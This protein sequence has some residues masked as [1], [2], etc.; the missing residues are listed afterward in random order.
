MPIQRTRSAA[1]NASEKAHSANG[2]AVPTS[3]GEKKDT[4]EVALLAGGKPDKPAYEREQNR[5]K[6][7]IDSL[8]AK[9]ATVRDKIGL[10][11]QQNVGNERRNELK[12]ELDSLRE[13]Q[14]SKKL[15]R[16]KL[17]DQVNSLQD[18]LQKKI[19]DLQAQKSKVSFKTVAEIDDRIASLEK[20]IES[21]NMKLADEKRALQE[22]S[23]IKRNR[24]IVDTFQSEQDAI[25]AIR[26]EIEDLKKQLDDPEAKAVSDRFETVKAELDEIKKENDEAYA[27]R[28]KLF[29]ERDNLNNQ[30]KDLLTEKRQKQFAYRDANDKYWAKLNED[31]A[32]RAE[33]QRAQRAAEEA[34]RK[35][36]IAQRI[37]DEAS[38]PAFQ[39]YIED[40]QTLVDFFSGKSSAT[41][42]PKSGSLLAKAEVAGVPKLEI[43][44]V[45]AVPEGVVVRKKKGEEEDNYFVGGK[46]RKG[47]KGGAPKAS[48]PSEPDSPVAATGSTS[49]KLNIPLGN[50]SALLAL[51]IPVPE[52]QADVPRVIED[53]NTKKAWYE[54]NQARVTAENI[55]K[56]ETEIARL[57]NS[58]KD[59]RA[60]ATATPSG[61]ETPISEVAPSNADDEKP[62]ESTEEASLDAAAQEEE[63]VA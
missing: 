30:I 58:A 11:T 35:L 38:A 1:P 55:A 13:Q 43:R 25:D 6:G 12:S 48:T 52:S 60:S 56:A 22:I 9:L 4:S 54:A 36:E 37:R 34:E 46:G 62:A 57:T 5:L 49:D 18:N 19:K 63:V 26:Q 39:S 15:N 41:V 24:R 21:G 7:E 40:C 20:Q 2:S 42:A 14:S 51:S 29:E 23:Q 44:Q 32:R 17:R 53:L 10:A 31:R 47:K 28:N 61:A 33:K 50:L 3:A 27:G 59:T 8:Q 16:G 45:E